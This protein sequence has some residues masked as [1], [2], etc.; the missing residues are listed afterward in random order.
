MRQGLLE[1]RGGLEEIDGVVVVLL[2]AGRDGEDVGIED[3]VLGRET[4]LVGKK[5]IGARANP[6]FFIARGGLALLIKRHHD[7]GGA[8]AA[9]EFCAAQEFGFAVLE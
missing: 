1:D 7:G 2:D 9:N 4:D 6:D 8:V 3:D 5:L